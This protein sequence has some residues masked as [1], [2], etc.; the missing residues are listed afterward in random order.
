MVKIKDFTK[1][2]NTSPPFP[3]SMRP[4]RLCSLIEEDTVQT[5]QYFNE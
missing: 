4:I 5:V 2:G 1:T 3:V